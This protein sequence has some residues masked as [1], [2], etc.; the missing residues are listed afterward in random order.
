MATWMIAFGII[1][2]LMPLLL[3]MMKEAKKL[4][5]NIPD[6]GEQKKQY[7]MSMVHTAA[8]GLCEFTGDELDEV[9]LF[10]D[11]ALSASVEFFYALFFDDDDD[12]EV[13]G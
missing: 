12:Q 4:F 11:N 6:S 5:D 13:S 7:V 8:L 2:K 1:I 10:V 3:N 9:V